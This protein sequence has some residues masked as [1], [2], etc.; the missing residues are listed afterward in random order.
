MLEISH[1]TTLLISLEILQEIIVEI[2]LETLL[3]NSQETM[4]GL[5][6][7]LERQFTLETDM[8]IILPQELRLI[9]EIE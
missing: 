5:Q 8:N 4:Q 9:Q 6:H 1:E 3:E 2:M 7:V